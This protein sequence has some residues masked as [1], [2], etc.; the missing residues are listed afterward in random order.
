MTI[1]GHYYQ[2]KLKLNLN[3]IKV[4]AMSKFIYLKTVKADIYIFLTL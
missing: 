2:T 4:N 3:P 1:V